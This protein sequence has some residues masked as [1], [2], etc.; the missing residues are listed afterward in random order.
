ML[1]SAITRP[2]A[3]RPPTSTASR[4]RS[5]VS[6]WKNSVAGVGAGGG[7]GLVVDMEGRSHGVAALASR[8]SGAFSPP[9][10][11]ATFP[12]MQNFKSQ[13]EPAGEAVLRR[14]AL[15]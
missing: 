4:M 10:H 3:R 2:V 15:A 7:V 5:G 13:P 14:L 1:F 12:T 9:P 6:W 11:Y 8:G